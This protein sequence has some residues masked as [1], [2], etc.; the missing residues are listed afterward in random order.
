MY[1]GW[2]LALTEDLFRTASVGRLTVV[3]VGKD[4]R[5]SSG[6]GL[7]LDEARSAG[8]LFVKYLMGRMTA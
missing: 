5:I 7:L 1:L 6:V 4:N 3:K 8:V 2:R